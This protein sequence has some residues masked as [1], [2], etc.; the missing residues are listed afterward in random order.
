[1]KVD[2]KLVKLMKL[3]PVKAQPSARAKPSCISARQNT[4]LKKIPKYSFVLFLF[5]YFIYLSEIHL[6][7]RFQFMYVYIIIRCRLLHIDFKY[8]KLPWYFPQLI[9]E[10][11]PT[12]PNLLCVVSKCAIKII[13]FI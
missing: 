5:L 3:I 7:S 12:F 8:F 4:S 13:R 6:V 9:Q 10:Y 2:N 11:I 1:M